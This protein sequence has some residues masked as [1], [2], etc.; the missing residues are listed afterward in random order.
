MGKEDGYVQTFNDTALGVANYNFTTSA[1]RPVI[2]AR[3][4]NGLFWKTFTFDFTD[5][6]NYVEQTS[7]QS[8]SCIIKESDDGTGKLYISVLKPTL[9]VS[10]E[11]LSA[12]T[13]AP[14]APTLQPSSSSMTG[15]LFAF[16]ALASSAFLLL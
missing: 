4:N 9:T 12:P 6:S 10:L 7:V 16:I 5:G 11:L 1:D 14:T 15:T 8:V 2:R 13:P 3:I